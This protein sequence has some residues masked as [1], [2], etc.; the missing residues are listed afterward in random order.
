MDTQ[1]ISILIMCITMII[2]LFLV[3]VFF[4]AFWK[5]LDEMKSL[6][7]GKYVRFDPKIDKLVNLAIDHWRLKKRI[8]GI[9]SKLSPDDIKKLDSSLH[10]IDNYLHENDI[11]VDDYTGRPANYGI[12]AEIMAVEFDPSIK[13]AIVKETV[14]P[15]VLYKG[16]LRKKSQIII[17]DNSQDKEP[18]N[19]NK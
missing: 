13:K 18:Q 16:N 10:R 12:N 5:Q 1:F 15:A 9:K 2:V 11:E 14:T 17:L 8:E 4:I 19:D 7:Y 6:M 3:I